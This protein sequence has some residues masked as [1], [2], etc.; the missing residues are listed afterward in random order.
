[1]ADGKRIEARDKSLPKRRPTIT[2]V[3]RLAS[4]SPTTASSALRG[5]GRMAQETRKRV[6]AAAS[7]L[8]Y[9]TDRRASALRRRRSGVLGLVMPDISGP[10]MWRLARAIE[11]EARRRGYFL[12]LCFSYGGGDLEQR[13]VRTLVGEGVEGLALLGP[14]S[15]K[16]GRDAGYLYRLGGLDI[17]FVF[18]DVYVDTVSA[19][20]VGSDNVLGARL[21]TEHLLQL[22]HRR[23]AYLSA[24]VEF[25]SSARERLQG[26]NAALADWGVELGSQFVVDRPDSDA[27]REGDPFDPDRQWKMLEPSLG[28]KLS[29]LPRPP[30]AIVCATTDD[31]C[32]ALKWAHDQ[33]LKIPEQLSVVRFDEFPFFAAVGLEFTFVRQPAEEIGSRV[34]EVLVSEISGRGSAGPVQLRLPPRL[35]VGNTTA[36]PGEEREEV[37]RQDQA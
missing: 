3:A 23:I 5:T 20:F 10:Y 24:P 28:K 27:T 32:V 13:L 29:S 14:L 25:V 35:V 17:P 12:L 9:E 36:P 2:D 7:R 21:A 22:G 37:R 34:L 16:G 4:V 19:P 8:A 30:S 15:R 33:G 11:T 18:V 6:L 31:A 26:F 1:M